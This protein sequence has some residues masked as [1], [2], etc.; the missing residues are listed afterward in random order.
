MVKEKPG[1]GETII[2]VQFHSRSNIIL[3]HKL[4]SKNMLIAVS[5]LDVIKLF[6][7]EQRAL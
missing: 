2:F 6:S 5:F 3:L 1:I 4:N 7:L